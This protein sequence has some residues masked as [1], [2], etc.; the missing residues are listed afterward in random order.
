MAQ[1]LKALICAS[2]L[3][4]LCACS[5][6]ESQ[7]CIVFENSTVCVKYN[8]ETKKFLIEGTT[9]LTDEQIQELVHRFKQF[10]KDKNGN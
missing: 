1:K 7:Y 5:S 8:P 10:L 3:V 6:I 4:I 2:A 9:N